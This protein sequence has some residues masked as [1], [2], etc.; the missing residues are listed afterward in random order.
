MRR[1]IIVNSELTLA[2]GVREVDM[3]GLGVYRLVGWMFTHMCET[4]NARR[5][6][7]S[8]FLEELLNFAVYRFLQSSEISSDFV[9]TITTLLDY[10]MQMMISINRLRTFMRIHICIDTTLCTL[11]KSFALKICIQVFTR[12][13]FY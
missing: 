13:I 8:F 6:V 11:T 3:G 9:D 10:N 4:T 5:V 2:L 7:W 1:W 12:N